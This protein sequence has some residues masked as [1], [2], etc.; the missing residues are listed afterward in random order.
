MFTDEPTQHE[1]IDDIMEQMAQCSR[2]YNDLS[3]TI[4]RQMTLD[5]YSQLKFR[6]KPRLNHKRNYDFERKAGKMEIPYFDGMD[7]MTT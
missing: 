6:N 2:E 4:Q 5:Q 7:N 3:M 1:P